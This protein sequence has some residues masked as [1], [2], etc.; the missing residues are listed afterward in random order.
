[1][2]KKS[3]VIRA[4]VELIGVID[5]FDKQ[6]QTK[7]IRMNR[8]DLIRNFSSNVILPHDE[9]GRVVRTLNEASKKK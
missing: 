5:R 6:M 2:D 1:M 8:M 3:V 7:G 4:P 9:I